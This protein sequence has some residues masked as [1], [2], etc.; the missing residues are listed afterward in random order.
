MTGADWLSVVA[1]GLGLALV[2]GAWWTQPAPVRAWRFLGLVVL[3]VATELLTGPNPVRW[4][5]AAGAVALVLPQLIR[6]GTWLARAFLL[7]LNDDSPS[8]SW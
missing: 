6:F 4:W 5:L 1:A 2:V 7:W 8:G 3:V